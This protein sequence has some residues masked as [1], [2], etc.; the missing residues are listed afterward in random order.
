MGRS[1]TADHLIHVG[2]LSY[3]ACAVAF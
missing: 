1:A 3:A 2:A